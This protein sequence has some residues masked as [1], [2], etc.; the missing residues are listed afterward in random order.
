MFYESLLARNILRLCFSAQ[1]IFV[2]L[3]LE[4]TLLFSTRY[5]HFIKYCYHGLIMENGKVTIILCFVKDVITHINNISHFS[6]NFLPNFLF[7][8][9]FFYRLKHNLFV[10]SHFPPSC[11]REKLHWGNRNRKKELESACFGNIYIDF[12]YILGF[13]YTHVCICMQ[14]ISGVL[15]LPYGLVM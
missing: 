12:V 4:K 11:E 13:T 14:G 7:F 1:S 10:I 15:L 8:F 3:E 9:F 6:L 5:F 2:V